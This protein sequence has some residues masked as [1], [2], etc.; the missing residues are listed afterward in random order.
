RQKW[1][2]GKSSEMYW[3]AFGS[4]SSG[5]KAPERTKTGNKKKTENWIACVC[6]REI[7]EM[8]N[9]R[10]NEQSKNRKQISASEPQ[11]LNWTWK[12]QALSKMM[13]RIKTIEMAR[14]GSTLPRTISRRRKAVTI[15]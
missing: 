3:I 12:C 15:N 10:P 13:T 2:S 7:A 14:Y 5:A 8:S 1:V 4:C 11:S 6:V 9:P